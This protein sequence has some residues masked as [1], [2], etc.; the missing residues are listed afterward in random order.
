MPIIRS[1]S[2][3]LILVPTKKAKESR[4]DLKD[5]PTAASPGASVRDENAEQ[6]QD[7]G[8]PPQASAVPPAPQTHT[9]QDKDS[10]REQLREKIREAK[11]R[12]PL[13]L[14]M[15][16]YGYG[17]RAKK[18]ARCPFHEDKHKSWS[19]WQ[20]DQSQWLF[21]CQAGCGAGD[22]INFVELIEKLSRGDAIKRYL[23]LAR[24]ISPPPCAQTADGQ[25]K[26][27]HAKRKP[28]VWQQYVL[29]MSDRYV[30]AIAAKRAFSVS[31]VRELRDKKQIGIYQG[32]VAFPVINDGEIVGAHFRLNDDIWNYEPKGQIKA[33]PMIFG[34]LKAGEQVHYFESTWDGLAYMD[35]TGERSGI[36][37][38]RGSGN[39]RFA[40]LIPEGCTVYAWK[41]ND[42]E[43]KGRRSGDDWL[44]KSCEHTKRSCTIKIPKIPVHDL[45]DWTRDGATED[46]IHEAKKNAW[47]VREGVPSEP[48]PST[49]ITPGT[50]ILVL[51]GMDP[52]IFLK[53][54]VLGNRL[55]CRGQPM[56]L[57]GPTGIGKSSVGV[58]QDIC[59]SCGRQAFGI[60]P[61]GPL[62]ILH[63]Q[64]EN[65]EGD[66]ADMA[67]G[68]IKHLGL[69]ERERELV[70]K[71]FIR[72]DVR[73]LAGWEFIAFLRAKVQV[74]R[75]DLARIDPLEA[76]AGGDLRDPK[77][78]TSFL[79]VSIDKILAEYLC[80]IIINHHTTKTIYRDTSEWTAND[81]AYAGAGGA[82][83]ANWPRVIMAI[84]GTDMRKVFKFHIAKRWT[85]SG[86]A[87]PNGDPTDLRVFCWHGSGDIFWQDATDD[88][89]EGLK[90]AKA[91]RPS[92]TKEDL[93]ALVPPTDPILKNVLLVKRPERMGENTARAFLAELVEAEEL[94]EYRRKRK[95]VRPELWISRQE[96]SEATQRSLGLSA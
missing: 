96:L 92:Y 70:R 20:G 21:K 49:L 62:K 10:A 58:Q 71:N 88:E 39:G 61:C 11:A 91:G 86:W 82:V 81:W 16:R 43:K 28:F 75:P 67:R 57:V 32:K 66:L 59:W 64:S 41:Q 29:A 79:R 48:D 90:R 36:I 46:D 84:E 95:S 40:A 30:E 37:I 4:E 7:S 31:F 27:A 35:K 23:K 87:S 50:P 24:D 34:E 93:K 85:R 51:A 68:I 83:I 73:G 8:P 2:G 26:S 14:L 56:L 9:G 45:N 53:D 38:T 74:H 18:S 13:P 1:A 6:G 54:S 12:L 52:E 19:V 3:K 33:A 22:E 89:V 63:I 69:T 78:A 15:A 65:D 17:D 94:F 42:E 44:E 55:L 80:A 77:T 60:R 72:Y 47:T 5:G 76:F 25:A